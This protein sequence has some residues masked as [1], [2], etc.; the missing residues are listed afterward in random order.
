MLNVFLGTN[1][2]LVQP[3]YASPEV[4]TLQWGVYIPVVFAVNAL[5]YRYYKRRL[6]SVG[7]N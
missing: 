2:F 7:D 1:F 6:L 3:R 4:T 5:I